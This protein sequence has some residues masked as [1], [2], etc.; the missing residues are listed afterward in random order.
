MEKIV[1]VEEML[2]TLL[3]QQKSSQ[4]NLRELGGIVFAINPKLSPSHPTSSTIPQE[5]SPSSN[6][7]SNTMSQQLI[8]K[9]SEFSSGNSA[10]CGGFP[11]QCKLNFKGAPQL[12]LFRVSKITYFVSQLKGDALQW[13]NSFLLTDNLD[14][15]PYNL[16]LKE[17]RRIFDQLL[18]EAN[19]VKRLLNL[20]QGKQPAA[21]HALNF[22]ILTSQT[23]WNDDAL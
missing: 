6:S 10:H 4:S 3:T 20:W 11:L 18:Q 7:V 22:C 13:A 2:Q 12:Y 5:P 19:A 16:F 17:L 9:P 14:S 1:K 8:V 23:K 15:V 21:D